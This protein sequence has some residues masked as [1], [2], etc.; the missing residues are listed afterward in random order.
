MADRKEKRKMFVSGGYKIERLEKLALHHDKKTNKYYLSAV[1]YA[2]D[3][4]GK[5]KIE[6]PNIKLNVRTDRL[7]NI[8]E[9]LVDHHYIAPPT[10]VQE[11]DLGFGSLRLGI[12]QGGAFKGSTYIMTTLEEK[13]QE[14]TL[15]EIEKK[16][17]YKIK[18]VS[19]KSKGGKK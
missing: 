3:D 7:P 18:I 9:F 15:E 17:G 19:E 1:Y 4:K 16:L 14:L 6:I 5:Y 10:Y 11:I 13:T 8:S 12:C 2:E